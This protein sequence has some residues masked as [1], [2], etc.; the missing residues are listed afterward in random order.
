MNDK[1]KENE[2]TE[3]SSVLYITEASVS[4][5]RSEEDLNVPDPSKEEIEEFFKRG[6]K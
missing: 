4:K 2:V 6:S 5:A 3:V 1:D